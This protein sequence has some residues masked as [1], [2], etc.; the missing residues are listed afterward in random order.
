MKNATDTIQ[1]WNPEKKEIAK[2]FNKIKKEK[3]EC[4]KS[5]TGFCLSPPEVHNFNPYP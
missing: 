2:H 4:I 3:N 5:V 1:L